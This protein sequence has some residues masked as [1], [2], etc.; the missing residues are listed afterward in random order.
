MFIRFSS[1]LSCLCFGRRS[2]SPR[3]RARS[4]CSP[5]DQRHWPGSHAM[6]SATGLRAGHLF[7]LAGHS[8]SSRIG[9]TSADR[10][11]R[12]PPEDRAAGHARTPTSPNVRPD[13]ARSSR[14]EHRPSRG[15]QPA[16]RTCAGSRLNFPAR[17]GLAGAAEISASRNLRRAE[18]AACA[19]LPADLVPAAQC[20]RCLHRRSICPGSSPSGSSP[21]LLHRSHS[22]LLDPQSL[23][24]IARVSCACRTQ[25]SNLFP[26]SRP[27]PHIFA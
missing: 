25:P 24:A 13:S 1:S 12:P 9:K 10:F 14:R 5:C 21:P 17:A 19:D 7:I 4:S 2:H 8:P 20:I 6:R 26:S 22:S 27:A 18:P 11:V 16:P 3:S 15:K 23:L